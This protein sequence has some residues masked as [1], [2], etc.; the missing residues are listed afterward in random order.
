M[1]TH[2]MPPV[3]DLAGVDAAFDLLSES[4]AGMTEAEARGD[5][6]LPGWSRGHVLS[7]IARNADGQ[8]HMVEGVLRDEVVEQYPGG[9]A[10]RV[11]EIE[12]G[13]HRP[14]ADLLGDVHESQ[15]ALVDAWS[16]V[17]DGAWDRLTHARAGIRPVRDGARSRWREILVHLV[18]LDVGVTPGALPS[19][20][21]ERDHAWLVEHRPR[22]T[23][24]DVRW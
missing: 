14:V 23:W 2:G 20:Y 12:A 21:V 15:R 24:P 3:A 11:E 19:A 9:D 10:Q 4:I 5:S 13:A 7:H 16:H 18:D 1:G 8:R 17:P 22:D 6:L